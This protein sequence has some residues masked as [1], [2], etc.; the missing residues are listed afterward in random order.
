M[1]YTG[2]F[3]SNKFKVKDAKKFKEYLDLSWGAD[4][5][6]LCNEDEFTLH[7]YDS[8]PSA[9]VDVIEGEE[10]LVGLSKHLQKGEIAVFQESGHEGLRYVVGYGV[11]VNH[12]GKFVSVNIHDDLV[13]AVKRTFRRD[14]NMC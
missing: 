4:I 12:R 9:Q 6:F 2:C 3:V 11:A 14:V 7:G 13:R 1:D 10:F 5:R 8:I